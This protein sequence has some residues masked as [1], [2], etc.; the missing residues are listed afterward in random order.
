MKKIAD[1]PHN[2]CTDPEHNPPAHQVF[3]PG[4]YEHKCPGC[5]TTRII[6]IGGSATW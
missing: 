4:I 3:P 1:L 5:G 6:T 2:P